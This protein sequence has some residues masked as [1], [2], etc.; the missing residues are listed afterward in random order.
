MN[1]KL[2]IHILML[3]IYFHVCQENSHANCE[4]NHK[5]VP[6]LLLQQFLNDLN[7]ML[8]TMISFSSMKKLY[9]KNSHKC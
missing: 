6:L 1:L 2:I 4:K 7:H 8:G 3:V 5:G 9:L